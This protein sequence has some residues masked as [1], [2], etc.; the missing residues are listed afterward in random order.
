[1]MK[2]LLLLITL[3]SLLCV[4]DEN[5]RVDRDTGEM[6]PDVVYDLPANSTMGGVI[7]STGGGSGDVVGPGGGSTDNAIATFDST[8]GLLLQN[9]DITFVG[10]VLN[11]PA[12]GN[13]AFDA[14][15]IIDDFGGVTTLQNVDEID[16]TTLAT[17]SSAIISL[18]NL[19]DVGTISVGTWEGGVID[20]AYIA[21]AATWDAKGDVSKVGTPVDNQIAIWTGDGSIEGDSGLTWDGSTLTLVAGGRLTLGSDQVLLESGGQIAL[22]AVNSIDAT[23]EATIEAAIDTLP[24]LAVAA[25]LG[26]VSTITVGVWQGTAIADAYVAG[27]AGW[28]SKQDGDADLDD[29]AD[30]TL[31][32]SRLEST[33]TLDAEWDTFSELNAVLGLDADVATLALEENTTI[34][35]FIRA[36]LDDA[37]PAAARTTLGVDAAGTDNSLDVTM[38]GTPDYITLTGQTIV[39]NLVDLTADVANVLPAANLPDADDD[40]STQGVAAFNDTDFN[41]TAG[42]VTLARGEYD[43]W[44]LAAGLFSTRTTNGAEWENEE[45]VTNDVQ[46]DH[47]NFDAATDEGIWCQFPTPENWDGGTI[48]VK[49]YWDSTGTGN[50]IWNVAARACGDSDAIDQAEGAGISVTDSKITTSDIHVSSATAAVTVQGSPAGGDMIFIQITRDADNGSDTLNADGEFYGA[51]VQYQTKTTVEA[52]W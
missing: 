17:L 20:D 11:L 31:S 14:V 37:D 12:S 3:A 13:V 46:V 51:L 49:F 36:V 39:R 28:D 50:V 1:M 9:T 40:G 15:V 8:T 26:E 42:V 19:T 47:Y 22:N 43:Y 32:A 30:G 34:S 10:G 52:A 4:A 2:H 24:S 38:V 29:L 23:T 48:K 33:V 5:V 41:A 18:V 7:I 21:G 16:A 27:A 25:Q 35:S 6:S 45:K 44:E